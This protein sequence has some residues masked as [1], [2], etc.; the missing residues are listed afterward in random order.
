MAVPV[1]VH[2][3]APVPSPTE[4]FGGISRDERFDSNDHLTAVLPLNGS[5]VATAPASDPVGF[6]VR[7]DGQLVDIPVPAGPPSSL[8]A[9]RA[10]LAS[11]GIAALAALPQS[12]DALPRGDADAVRELIWRAHVDA[13]RDARR[14]ELESGE[15][16]AG[17]TAMRYWARTFGE[18]PARGRSL[19]ISMHG[20]GG[21][22]AHVNDRQWENQKGLYEPPE[23]IYLVPR[24][25]TDT[26]NLWHQA[27]VDALLARLID[28][29]VIAGEADPD[30]VYIMGYSAGGDGVYQLAPRMAD[31]LAAAAMM[32]GHPNDAKPDG[33]RNIGFALHMGENDTPYGRNAVAV[34]WK[35]SLAQLAAADSGGYPHQAV[36]HAGKGHWM[37]RQ[38]AMALPWMAGFTRNPRP[39][40]VVWLQDDVVHR[41]SYWLEV[42]TPAQGTRIEARRSGNAI[43]I[44]SSGDVDRLT[45]HLDDSMCDLD[46]P[47]T[48]TWNGATVHSGPVRRSAAA[49][50]RSLAGRA[51]PAS[52]YT[53]Q[54]AVERPR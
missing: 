41:R 9:I 38:D 23:G 42:E 21:A 20:G 48:V 36:I 37:D 44:G 4:V 6:T 15:V 46:A 27:H 50:L 5:F 28:S 52:L 35:D 43:V 51:D 30:R 12:H 39:D 2:R 24:A 49:V 13:E 34:Q 26:W 31:R 14:R 3:D 8:A 1:R 29:M 7:E 10:A 54:L 19:W 45:I 11:G 16:R 25:P 47:V 32:A 17:D 33:L 22:P 53:A 18:R 40:R